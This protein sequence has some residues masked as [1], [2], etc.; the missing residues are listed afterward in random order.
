MIK[1]LRKYQVSMPGCYCLIIYLMALMATSCSSPAEEDPPLQQWTDFE[2]IPIDT[3]MYVENRGL[4]EIIAQLNGFEFRLVADSAESGDRAFHL[5]S[6]S[7]ITLNI[8][9]KI[10]SGDNQLRVRTIGEQGGEA[11]ILI[12]DLLL[13][14]DIVDYWLPE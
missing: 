6:D 3:F 14:G 13:P 10:L 8:A 11:T 4:S 9:T 7:A 5:P 12:S 1:M 2:I